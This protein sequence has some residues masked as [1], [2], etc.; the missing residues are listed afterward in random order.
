MPFSPRENTADHFD[1]L[2]N[3]PPDQRPAALEEAGPERRARLES[4]LRADEAAELRTMWQ[5]SALDVQAK[6][7]VRHDPALQ[8]GLR[9]GAYRVVRTLGQGG[10]GDVYLAVRDDDAYEKQVAIKLIQHGLDSEEALRRFR[11]ERRILA[12]MEHPNIARL[13]DGG[14]TSDGLPYLV[15]EHVD[16]L[17]LDVYIETN[18]PSLAA[19]LD[20]FLSI[21]SAVRYAHRNLVVHR[22]LKPGNIMVDIDGVP[23]LLDFGIAA[24]LGPA[25]PA[26]NRVMTYGYASPEQLRGE[27]TTTSTDVFALGVLLFQLLTGRRPFACPGTDPEE[28]ARAIE[29][30]WP[31]PMDEVDRDW[32]AILRRALAPAIVDRYES[33]GALMRDI[34]AWRNGRPVAARHGGRLYRAMRFLRRNRWTTLAAAAALGALLTGIVATTVQARRAERRF[35]E[36][37]TLANSLL[38]EFYDSVKDVPGSTAARE[39]LVRRARQYLDSLAD[40]RAGD[41][42]LQRELAEAYWKLGNIQG[43]PYGQN[44]GDSAGALESFHRARTILESC[45]ASSP[46]DRVAGLDLVHTLQAEGAGMLRAGRRVE[47]VTAHRR[48]LRVAEELLRAEPGD[49]EVRQEVPQCLRLLGNAILMEGAIRNDNAMGREALT[50][51]RRALRLQEEITQTDPSSALM[52]TK[53]GASLA[54]VGYALQALALSAGDRTLLREALDCQRRSLKV[55]RRLAVDH[56]EDLACRRN[57]GDACNN[58]GTTLLADHEI[59]AA[60]ASHREALVIDTRLVADDPSN[61]E[62]R[63]DLAQTRWLLARALSAAGRR[64]QARAFGHQAVADYQQLSKLD[65]SDAENQRLLD[66]AEKD[67]RSME[68]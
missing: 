17:P 56:P 12:Q 60:L 33:V 7:L 16:G 14:D 34:S 38:F 59:D 25:D 29:C 8:I 44:I 18:A 68:H 20:L 32:R 39:L 53:L 10:M 52:Q 5:G 42:A 28:C 50:I 2:A 66:M 63:R 43:E 27:P 19:Q 58:Y 67:W 36:V 35:N 47:A 1:R 62:A 30:Q 11:A 57:L 9:L 64:V 21:C 22:D 6:A 46:S 13:I 24:L 3:L 15:M 23:K 54:Y 26:A 65:P 61:I 48:A 41:E 51:Y 45:L 49:R 55:F 37:R 31:P 40:D 4:L